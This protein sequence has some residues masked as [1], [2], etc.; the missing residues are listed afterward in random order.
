MSK[1]KTSLDIFIEAVQDCFDAHTSALFVVTSD[2]KGQG[3]NAGDDFDGVEAELVS[4]SSL[5]DKVVEDARLR[6]GQGLLGWSLK[7]GEFLH[8]TDFKRDTRTLGIY[9]EDVGIK[10]IMVSPIGGRRCG[11]LM[12]DSRNQFTFSEKKQRQF[13][14]MATICG[15]L[16]DSYYDQARLGFLNRFVDE[17]N[18]L[19]TGG[20]T[21]LKAL[22]EIT[23]LD[24][25]VKLTIRDG[26][27]FVDIVVPYG[28]HRMDEHFLRDIKGITSLLIKHR[29][30]LLL[31]RFRA[32]NGSGGGASPIGPTV[33]GIPLVDR[34]GVTGSVWILSGKKRLLGWP[35]GLETMLEDILK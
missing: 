8:A 18:R 26:R 34:E 10:A 6:A 33:M 31:D 22:L 20:E 11:V 4:C 17:Y 1:K 27:A 12:V 7:S 2:S 21:A 29:R 16:V 5:S 19:K 23:T 28:A 9:S 13:R 24:I 14:S 32:L 15:S 30:P 25:G 35:K 3:W